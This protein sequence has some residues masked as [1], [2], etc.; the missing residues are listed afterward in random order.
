MLISGLL[1]FLIGVSADPVLTEAQIQKWVRAFAPIVVHD[2]RETAALTSVEG[3][4]ALKPL[5]QGTCVDGA[6]P[7]LAVESLDFMQQTDVQQLVQKCPHEL[8][9]SFNRQISKP[10]PVAYYAVVTDGLYVKLQY[11]LYYAWND[12]SQLGG[13]GIVQQCGEHEGDWEHVS[14]RLDR[15]LIEQ[16]Q[17]PE[18]MRDA[19]DDVYLAQHHRKQHTERKYF[20]GSDKQLYFQGTQLKVFPALGSHATY[21]QPGRYALM[22]L[23]GI[24]IA[25]INDG[26]GLSFNLAQGRL[27]SIVKQP[28]FT[29]PGRWGAVVHDNCDV[30]EAV[31]SASNDGSFGPGHAHKVKDLYEGDWHDQLRPLARP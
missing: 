19:I 18:Q 16:A 20:R 27:E 30:L 10:E 9:L 13:G 12:A 22:T 6:R 29:F 5:L 4:L 7:S 15:R 17:T 14:I 1:S 8:A 25:D 26:L 23:L 2:S 24:Q 31:S 3:Q 28:W 11:W 21:A